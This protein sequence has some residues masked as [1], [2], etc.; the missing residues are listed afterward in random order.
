MNKKNLILQL[1]DFY[2]FFKEND[3]HLLRVRTPL[4][5]SMS[6]RPAQFM[7]LHCNG[8]KEALNDVENRK[9]ETYNSLNN[10]AVY[11]QPF[12]MSELIDTLKKDTCIDFSFL[13]TIIK[14]HE[15]VIDEL[16]NMLNNTSI[17]ITQYM[18]DDFSSCREPYNIAESFS[19]LL[20]NFLSSEI[21]INFYNS[22]KEELDSI[23]DFTIDELIPAY[24]NA[25]YP[26]ENSDF[27]AR[28]KDI[29]ISLQLLS[30][31]LNFS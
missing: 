16:G 13:D 19:R 14:E 9:I 4:V 25:P 6:Y 2:Q 10:K 3:C 27:H 11:M 17:S 12:E 31:G 1:N 20:L 29:Y 22:H 7:L 21:E 5:S 15:A 28:L 26:L 24:T 18:E 30:E 8:M 23:L